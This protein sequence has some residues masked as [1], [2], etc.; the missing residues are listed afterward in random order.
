[1][2]TQWDV[3]SNDIANAFSKQL[4][5][6][7]VQDLPDANRIPIQSIASGIAQAIKKAVESTTVLI[8]AKSLSLTGV[9]DSTSPVMSVTNQSDI[10]IDEALK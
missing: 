6:D 5:K 4:G 8:P 7:N 2:A 3:L 9:P 10:T 1:M